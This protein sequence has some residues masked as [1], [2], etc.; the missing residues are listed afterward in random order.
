MKGSQSQNLKL[1]KFKDFVS[2]VAG[3][4]IAGTEFVIGPLFVLHGV[5]A[6]DVLL[7]LLIG[8]ILAT[9]SWTLVC[10]PTAVKTRLTN[11]FQLERICGFR[12]V[13]VYNL[14]NGLCYA[15]AAAAM[16]GVSASA[17]GILLDIEGP[18]LTSLYPNSVEWVVIII[19]VGSV[20]A[21]SRHFWI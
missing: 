12:L 19:A 10:A 5:S 6:I 17:I 2:L 16:I 1:K 15:V 3:E 11:F 4:H 14:V 9:L 8:N 13:S 7:G 21:F 18:G 20:I